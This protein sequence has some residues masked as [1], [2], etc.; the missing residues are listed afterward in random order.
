MDTGYRADPK[1]FSQQ[2]DTFA[3][4]RA[5]DAPAIAARWRERNADIINWWTTP[6]RWRE[7]LVAEWTGV[8]LASRYT[9]DRTVVRVAHPYNPPDSRQAIAAS[10][11]AWALHTAAVE[12]GAEVFMD[13]YVFPMVPRG[14]NRAP[15]ADHPHA[16]L[17]D[18][19]Q[20]VLL[21]L[22]LARRKF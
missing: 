17:L 14:L 5:V 1:T 6:P 20:H 2:M 7:S 19:A 15:P 18:R 4:M 10:R 21:G 16:R 8:D 12:A 22:L 11:L 3:R 13:E 9:K